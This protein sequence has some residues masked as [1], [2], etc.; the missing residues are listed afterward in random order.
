MIKNRENLLQISN[1]KTKELR[2]VMLD[3]L[4]NALH[5]INISKILSKSLIF[6]KIPDFGDYNNIYVLGFGKASGH[7]AEQIESILGINNITD[8]I[9]IV[10]KNIIQTINLKK[11]KILEA[12]HPIPSGTNI[13]A[14]T[15]FLKMVEKIR[16]QNNLVIL[17]ISGG[18]SAL[19]TLPY[20]DIN[21]KDISYLT[22][23][24]LKSGADIKEINIIR[25]HYD[26]FK[27]GKLAK[28]LYPAHIVSFL[29]SD[30]GKYP[31]DIIASGPTYPCK[32]RFHDVM[33]ILEKYNLVETIP[34]SI[35]EHIKKGI[36][37]EIPENPKEN[38]PCFINTRNI[39]IGSIKTVCKAVSDYANKQNITPF[40]YPQ[41]IEGEAK[42]IGKKIIDFANEIY[43]TAPKHVKPLL[44]IAGGETTV[45][46]K[47][48]GKGGRCQELLLGAMKNLEIFNQ[49][50]MIAIGT[51]GI[52]GNSDAAGA[53]IDNNSFSIAHNMG[54][55]FEKFLQHNDSYTFFKELGHNLIFTGPTGT[56]VSDL[57]LLL[58]N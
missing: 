20:E 42:Y 51:D 28:Q 14:S 4:E 43:I 7:M 5:S 35:L 46:I 16:N 31:P 58:L 34:K 45:T 3:I 32:S 18:G 38:D 47:G 41:F 44:F 12:D 23:L 26:K 13:E 11:I 9:V 53:I 1:H 25:K 55:N 29:I 39:I 6:D 19:L 40:I 15:K 57:V 33:Q 10:P 52:D 17:L 49:A 27:G 48:S 24:L 22:E 36:N 56:N 2:R 30:V 21:L 54:L 50:I 37:G 8:G